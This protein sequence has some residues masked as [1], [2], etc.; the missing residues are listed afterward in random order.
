MCCIYAQRM[1]GVHTCGGRCC[2]IT[3]L[4]KMNSKKN[5]AGTLLP[6]T[7]M[8]GITVHVL[9][10]LQH[11]YLLTTKEVALG[12]GISEYTLRRH[13]MEQS[14][15]LIEGK[16]FITAVQ[17][18]NGEMQG[19]LKI[20]HNTTLWTKAG[21]IRLGFFIRS[22]RAKL[23]RDWAENLVLTATAPSA[24]VVALPAKRKHNRL[25]EARLLDIMADVCQ[26]DNHALRT[27]IAAKLMGGC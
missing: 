25:T 15:E 24:G 27:R 6:T 8:Q 11:E 2:F 12:Y 19:A 21:V 23:F 4:F 16:H 7:V 9:P 3:I 10:N 20:P 18:L 14:S 5:E 13:K 22:E 26:I 17:I 1:C